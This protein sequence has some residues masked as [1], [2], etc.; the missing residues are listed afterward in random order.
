MKV[1][2][3]NR[4]LGIYRGGGETFT[5]RL[6]EA[7]QKQNVS[8]RLIAGAKLV[9]KPLG[10]G[11]VP[12]TYC[13][14]PY[15]RGLSY[16]LPGFVG[17]RLMHFDRRV[18]ARSAFAQ[19]AK[20]KP[21]LVQCM[22]LPW[23]ADRIQK[24]LGLPAIIRF[25]GPPD[26]SDL[27]AIQAAAA[28]VA[29]G[30]AYRVIA[31]GFRSDAVDIPPGVDLGLFRPVTTDLRSRLGYAADTALFLFV[32]RLVPLKNLPFLIDAFGRVHRTKPKARL[33][34]V[35]DGPLGPSLRR[36][37]EAQAPGAVR[38]EGY[39]AQEALA[40]WYSAAD[41]VALSSSY[42]NFPNVLLEAMACERSIVSTRV[43]G[44]ETLLGGRGRLVEPNDR[45]G[46][47]QALLETINDPD[48][49]AK[50]RGN[51]EWV[52][53][54]Y[55]W[56]SSAAKFARLYERVLAGRPAVSR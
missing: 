29:N 40:E 23:L 24:E 37:A 48:R 8:V 56:E 27:P 3:V 55:A 28:V 5:I 16:R 25:P 19:L 22:G 15:M 18:F 10:T 14:T 26:R 31:S 44:V 9:G 12:V 52:K 43:G 30:D 46:F 38:F 42:D 20:D 13:R 32:G 7:L 1:A 54:Q 51:R 6:A 45:D 4:G 39:V 33:L 49:T 53:A 11:T 36:Q 17:Y 34:I 2:I 50:A 47:A 41:V 35:G 21:D